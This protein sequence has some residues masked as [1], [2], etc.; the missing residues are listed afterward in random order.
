MQG[1]LNAINFLLDHGA[2]PNIQDPIAELICLLMQGGAKVN[3][4]TKQD[5]T[6]L[7]N[8]RDYNTEMVN[9]M[10]DELDRL[11]NICN[12]LTM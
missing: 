3:I 2:D 9:I 10:T 6:A 5:S 11:N 7:D 8:A 4:L 12:K 1:K